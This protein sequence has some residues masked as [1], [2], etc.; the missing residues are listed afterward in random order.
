M[1]KDTYNK[2]EYSPPAMPFYVDKWLSNLKVRTYT[3]EK[4]SV[5]IELLALSWKDEHTML[6]GDVNVLSQICNTSPE[7]ISEIIDDHFLKYRSG[8]HS[9]IFNKKLKALKDE[10]YENHKKRVNAGKKGGKAKP[11]HCLNNAKAKPKPFSSSFSSSKNIQSPNGDSMNTVQSVTPE[12]VDKRRDDINNML[13]AL[14]KTIGIEHFVD[15]KL[16]RNMARHCL[17]LIE[18]IGGDEFKRRLLALL[19]EPFTKKNCNKIKF[20]YNNIKG[21]IEPKDDKISNYA[22]ADQEV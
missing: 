22:T 15:S 4:R 3:H 8:S 16:E 13:L 19:D 6:P 9:R 17:G 5:Y 2:R 14:K 7:I 10:M 21:F 20:V 1:T 12:Q 11:K 18:K